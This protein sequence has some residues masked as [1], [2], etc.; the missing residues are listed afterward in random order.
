MADEKIVEYIAGLARISVED[1]EKERLGIQLSKI[2]EYIDKLK[3]VDVRGIEPMRGLHTER[4]V[5]R[6]DEVEEFAGKEEILKNSPSSEDG[7]FKIH[8]VID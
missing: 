6:K 2:I 3:E 4:N 7:C 8:K 1:E 5:F